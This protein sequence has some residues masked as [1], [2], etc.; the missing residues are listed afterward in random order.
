[1][2]PGVKGAVGFQITDFRFPFVITS[3]GLRDN[4][5]FLVGRLS[6]HFPQLSSILFGLM[7]KPSNLSAAIATKR[8]TGT[9]S[10]RTPRAGSYQS[11]RMLL[12][13]CFVW[14]R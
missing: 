11:A 3:A 7:P 13:C 8:S 4:C 5:R 2:A 9:R 10:C 6:S 14:C 1:M 12:F